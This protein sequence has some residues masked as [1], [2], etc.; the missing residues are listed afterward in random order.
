MKF[1]RQW[2]SAVVKLWLEAFASN[3]DFQARIE[4]AKEKNKNQNELTNLVYGRATIELVVGVTGGLVVREYCSD[5]EFEKLTPQLSRI[6]E[7]A[8]SNFDFAWQA[9]HGYLKGIQLR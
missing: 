9:L 4:D 7:H 1:D 8:P 6:F 2:F 5:E 3:L